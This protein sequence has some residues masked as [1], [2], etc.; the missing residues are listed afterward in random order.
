MYPGWTFEAH[1]ILAIP[2]TGRVLRVF[3]KNYLRC[4]KRAGDLAVTTTPRKNH[5]SPPF[6]FGDLRGIAPL[7]YGDAT[8]ER[9]FANTSPVKEYEHN[10]ILI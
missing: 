10:L 3:I 1:I 2:P 5:S 7:R 8:I 6:H 9:I 4:L